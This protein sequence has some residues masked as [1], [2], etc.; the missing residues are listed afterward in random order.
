[1]PAIKWVPQAPAT[2]DC[3]YQV[4]IF[5]LRCIIAMFIVGLVSASIKIGLE[6]KELRFERVL[7]SC[8][9]LFKNLESVQSSKQ[10]GTKG[11]TIMK[12]PL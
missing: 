9:V 2:D 1:M 8:L 6:K 12:R 5:D 10:A 3:L 11:E 7:K 4:W